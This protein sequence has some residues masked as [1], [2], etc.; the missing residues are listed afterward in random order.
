LKNGEEEDEEE[1]GT[2]GLGYWQDAV[3]LNIFCIMKNIQV[4]PELL[5]LNI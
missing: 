4:L 2:I 5:K 3:R 1:K